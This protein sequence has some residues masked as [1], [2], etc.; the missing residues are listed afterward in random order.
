MKGEGS[1]QSAL[2]L[3]ASAR[4]LPDVTVASFEGETPSVGPGSWVHPSA[5]VIGDVRIGAC[6]WIGPGARLRG[7]YGTIVLGDRCAVEDN[8][9]VHAR[10]GETCTIGSWVTLGHGCIVH[11]AAR[12]GDFAVVGMGAVVSDW[13]EIGEWG[14]VAEGA[15]VPQRGVVP[16]GRIAAGV[17]ARLLEHPV[18][19]EFRS[20]WRGFKQ[21]YVELCER[22][23]TGSER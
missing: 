2:S 17:P 15:V 19:E 11:N 3:T 14:V 4:V 6:C 10:P 5:D 13:A 18:D 8:C 16:A 20:A 23:R 21:I 1:D 7:D 22:Y 12:I 9:V